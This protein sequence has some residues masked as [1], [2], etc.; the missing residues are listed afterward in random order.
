MSGAAG[1]WEE[2]AP[3]GWGDVW[4]GQPVGQANKWVDLCCWA[5][6]PGWERRRRLTP[7]LAVP[8][9]FPEAWGQ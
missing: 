6:C 9:H 8:L 3:K 7:V 2:L 1:A 4:N 5:Q